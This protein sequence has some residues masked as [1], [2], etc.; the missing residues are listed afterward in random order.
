MPYEIPNNDIIVFPNGTFQN[1]TGSTALTSSNIINS[2][3]KI[4]PIDKGD[5]SKSITI[6]SGGPNEALSGQIISN[7][8][9]FTE[10][11]KASASDNKTIT[12]AFSLVNY[13]LIHKLPILNSKLTS[14]TG[15]SSQNY[16]YNN[17]KIPDS[18]FIDNDDIS[19]LFDIYI[20]T[21]SGASVSDTS[22]SVEAIK[23][24]LPIGTLITFPSSGEFR[25]TSVANVGDTTLTGVCDNGISS[26][27]ISLSVNIN[28]KK[29][30]NIDSDGVTTYT[31]SDT[32]I[33]ITSWIKRSTEKRF[34]NNIL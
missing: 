21:T 13:L 33:Q 2:G 34:N 17:Y 28:P 27:D 10:F 20:I 11:K 29:I 14:P 4:G 16:Y 9:N 15:F 7:R 30:E 25:L 12:N 31:N 26:G 5:V 6:A 1:T 8:Y 3:T 24:N 22:L 23:H 32:S 18:S 19:N